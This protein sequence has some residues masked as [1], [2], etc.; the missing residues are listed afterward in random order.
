MKWLIIAILILAKLNYVN[1]VFV[2]VFVRGVE[3]PYSYESWKYKL[4]PHSI[5][6]LPGCISFVMTHK[7][8]YLLYTYR[9]P[10]TNGVYQP[11]SWH[12]VDYSAPLQQAVELAAATKKR[13]RKD[14]K[15]L[16]R[17]ASPFG[18]AVSKSFKCDNCEQISSIMVHIPKFQIVQVH[19]IHL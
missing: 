16:Y 8:Y 5:S 15:V 11:C 17:A 19:Y 10:R 14:S 13:V 7:L 6:Y 18:S 9:V 3:V 4:E 2:F 1:K 12:Q